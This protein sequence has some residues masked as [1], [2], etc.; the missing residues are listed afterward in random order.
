[1]I[2]MKRGLAG[3]NQCWAPPSRLRWDSNLGISVMAGCVASDSPTVSNCGEAQPI[4][5]FWQ[6]HVFLPSDQPATQLLTPMSQW[7]GSASVV[8]T[9]SAAAG[10][11]GSA[12]AV[13][14]AGA[15]VA[16][17]TAVATD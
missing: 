7:K 12:G 3:C 11:A 10:T 8:G 1:M 13:G 14:T 4:C 9:T 5:L 17:G 2:A 16:M 15:A 6:H